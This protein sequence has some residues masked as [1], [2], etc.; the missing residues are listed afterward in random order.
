MHNHR[1]EVIFQDY[2][3]DEDDDGVHVEVVD[4]DDDGV[5]VEVVDEDVGDGK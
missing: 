4:E 3:H 5:H 1:L 2:L